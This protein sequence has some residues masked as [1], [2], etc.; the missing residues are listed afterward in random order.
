[1]IVWRQAEI[2]REFYAIVKANHGVPLSRIIAGIRAKAFDG[3]RITDTYA[4]YCFYG[5]PC[6]I[7][8]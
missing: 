3:T 7:V 5:D 4:A 6:A 8:N 2:A 1:M